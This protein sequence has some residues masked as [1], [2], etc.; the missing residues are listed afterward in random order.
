[1]S[2]GVQIGIIGGSG[3]Y[4][5]EGLAVISTEMIATPN[6]AKHFVKASG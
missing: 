1:M 6:N 4:E 3:L 2:E 5:M